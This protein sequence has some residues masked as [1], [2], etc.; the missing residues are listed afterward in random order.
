M[1]GGVGQN[2]AARAS[3]SAFRGDVLVAQ[4]RVRTIDITVRVLAFTSPF[5]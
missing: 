3:V 2:G 1:P 5:A 4:V